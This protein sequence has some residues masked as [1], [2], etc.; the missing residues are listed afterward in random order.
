[1]EEGMSMNYGVNISTVW[2]GMPLE[3]QLAKVA[4]AGFRSIEFWFVARMDMPKLMP[5]IKQHELAV[6]LFN[7]DPDPQTNTGYLG[8]PDGE[9]RFFETLRDGLNWAGRLGTKQIH[10]MIGRRSERLER[11]A[12]RALIVERLRRGASMAADAGVTLLLEPLN[13]FDRP[14]YYLHH[15]AEALWIIDE[16]GAPNVKLQYD[17]Y[18]MQLMEGNLT[19]TMRAYLDRIG[20]LQLADAPGRKKPGQGEINYCTVL[21]A[22]RAAG[23]S[24]VIG[25]EYN[26]PPDDPNPFDWLPATDPAWQTP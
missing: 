17:F 10:V 22:V 12:Q 13:R 25:L 5:L 3:E 16:V 11:A 1:M 26:A 14:D 4:A 6:H 24:G 2:A 8:E 18:H 21:A 15:S 7:L 23:Y 20:H 9:A 19:N